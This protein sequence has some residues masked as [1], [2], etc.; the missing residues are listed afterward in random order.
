LVR[1]QRR[2]ELAIVKYCSA[3]NLETD[4]YALPDTD[5][6]YARITSDNTTTNFQPEY[7]VTEPNENDLPI[8]ENSI[9]VSEMR[10]RND[11]IVA[12]EPKKENER[13]REEDKEEED[14]EEEEENETEEHI[15]EI[16]LR[17]LPK[18]SK[19]TLEEKG[20]PNNLD[21]RNEAEKFVNSLRQKLFSH[22]PTS[23]KSASNMQLL[24]QE[25]SSTTKDIELMTDIKKM[26]VASETP[27]VATPHEE[28]LQ[29]IS[30]VR[31]L[32]VDQ[33]LHE[34]VARAPKS[35]TGSLS[36]LFKPEPQ[37]IEVIERQ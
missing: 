17:T 31:E 16:P 15:Y 30:L 6:R 34:P 33:S 13:E 10:R 25:I 11:S 5:G 12:F 18:A 26:I 29:R 37:S 28:S 3:T 20:E 2:R 1:E 35:F 36:S 21:I 4:S 27:T 23:P 19:E 22:L 32:A 24:T 8:E 7:T 9:S 14:K